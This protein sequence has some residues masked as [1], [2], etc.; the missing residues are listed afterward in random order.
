MKDYGHLAA[1]AADLRY[2]NGGFSTPSDGEK[3]CMGKWKLPNVAVKVHLLF[4][5]PIVSGEKLN[6]PP[7]HPKSNCMCFFFF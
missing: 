4:V 6:L 3:E 2:G 7:D 5:P 1:A